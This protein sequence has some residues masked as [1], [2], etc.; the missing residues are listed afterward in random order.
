MALTISAE[1]IHRHNRDLSDLVDRLRPLAIRSLARM[2]R[3]DERLF[4]FRLRR[5][6]SNIVSEG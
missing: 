2:Y 3:P 4:A 6:A 5:L 1:V